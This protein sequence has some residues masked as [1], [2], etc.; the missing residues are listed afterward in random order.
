MKAHPALRMG[1]I[2]LAIAIGC[3]FLADMEVTTLDPWGEMGRILV[4]VFT[5]NLLEPGLL[6]IALGKTIAF[7]LVGVTLA[8]LG[9]F[10]LALVYHF[11][12]VKAFSA[13]IRA[14][15]EL[16]W[17]LLFLQFIGLTPLT[18]LLA[19]AVPFSGVFAKVYSEI[20]EE[21]N[22]APL[23]T[24]PPGTGRVSAFFYVRLPDVWPHIVSYTAYRLECAL[25]SSAILGFVGLPTL[26]YYLETYFREGH[27]SE[28]SALLLL[29]FL[30]IA[31]LRLWVRPFALPWLFFGSLYWLWELPET[32]WGVISRFFTQDIV[33]APLKNG[34][35]MDALGEWGWNLLANQALPGIISTLVLTQIALVSTAF[36]TLLLF[37]I[38]SR[39]FFGRMGRTG[40]H[41][42]LVV[43][44]STPE[45][46]LTFVFLTMWGPSMLPAI[47][48]L[49]IHNAAI[50][51][52]LTGR[53]ADQVP[54]RPDSPKG[55]NRYFYE[56]LPRIYGQFL[57]FLFYR[58]E[59]ILRETSILGI[60]GIYTL[61]F[62]VDSG[63]QD[64]RLDRALLLII[65]TALLN[66]GVDA[67][68]RKIRTRLRL[69]TTARIE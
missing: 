28:V 20:L 58:W 38:V 56:V 17:A 51:A 68:S 3:L 48:A 61:G 31:S 18:G 54:L 23:A 40:G 26:G 65:I 62:Y 22:T 11:F 43:M 42:M 67:L 21:A 34:G 60:L 27:Y 9:G 15:H 6:F 19:I 8:S 53:Y 5:P 10:A 69:S 39:Q 41:I 24:L 49:A 2:F 25:R 33:P 57:A 1:L 37:P 36:L 29:F 44:R 16:F 4:G 12:W 7:A 66:I 47:V 45:Y 63:I 46:I 64:L 35:G 55:I 14:V 52:H 59:V 13:A 30:L 32:S 50:I